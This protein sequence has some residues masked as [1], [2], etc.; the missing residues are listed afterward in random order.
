MR[1]DVYVHTLM[2]VYICI[3]IY[4]CIFEMCVYI[5]T[6]ICAGNKVMYK[7]IKYTCM[8]TQLC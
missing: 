8:Y 2:Y 7:Q 5:H 4:I 3:Y 6:Y 1:V